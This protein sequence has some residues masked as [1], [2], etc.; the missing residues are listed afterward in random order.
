MEQAGSIPQQIFFSADISG[1]LNQS[2]G[3]QKPLFERSVLPKLLTEYYQLYSIYR[4]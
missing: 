4:I 3:C 1:D 2:H